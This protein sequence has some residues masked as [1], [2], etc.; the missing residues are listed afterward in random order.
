MLCEGVLNIF[1]RKISNSYK[2]TQIS[3]IYY[4]KQNLWKG[5]HNL[6]QFSN[7]A[8][9]KIFVSEVWFAFLRLFAT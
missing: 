9:K 2:Y 1:I 6:K 8:T 4:I 5:S 7:D 3:L